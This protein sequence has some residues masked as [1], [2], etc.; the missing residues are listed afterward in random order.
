IGENKR[1]A[2]KRYASVGL[3]GSQ[4]LALKFANAHGLG[5]MCGPRSRITVLDIDST[6]E[7]LLAD[8]LGRHG[9]S[10][11]IARTA[12]RK[13]HVYY[14]HANERRRVRAWDGRPL[15]L[16]GNGLVVAPPSVTQHGGRYEFVAGNLDD[17]ER[18]PRMRGLSP[19][20]YKASAA[21]PLPGG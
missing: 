10:P 21:N 1:P 8:A 17:L 5:F 14:R 6:D 3:R 18:L 19:E 13:W 2:I 7:R 20:L 16:L 4:E 11:L 9:A 15:D 12:S